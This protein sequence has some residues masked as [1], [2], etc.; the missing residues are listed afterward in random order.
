MRTLRYVNTTPPG[1][2]W[3]FRTAEGVW[4][5]SYRSLAE[6]MQLLEQYYAVNRITQPANLRAQVEDYICRHVP[7][8]F[9]DGVEVASDIPRPLTFFEAVQ[10]TEKYFR[11]RKF[12]MVPRQQAEARAHVC[13]KCSCN[14]LGMCTK[15]NGLRS[16]ASR[17]VGGRTLS[18]DPY[19]GVCQVTKLPMSGLV[20]VVVDPKPVGL[21][22]TCWIYAEGS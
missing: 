10:E 11:G 12:Q 18:L 19:L 1:G 14:M 20:H 22:A 21:P 2:K 17:F 5:E 9:C 8:G 7:S 15:C 13:K 4:F 16:L 6:L 3:F